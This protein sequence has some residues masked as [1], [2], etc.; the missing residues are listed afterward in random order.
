MHTLLKTAKLKVR[1]EECRWLELVWRSLCNSSVGAVCLI[2]A[3]NSY[4]TIKEEMA[5]T[6]M[7]ADMRGT[8]GHQRVVAALETRSCVL[9]SSVKSPGDLT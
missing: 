1:L 2:L 7:E 3:P 9:F 5:S 8:Q 4:E 6:Q